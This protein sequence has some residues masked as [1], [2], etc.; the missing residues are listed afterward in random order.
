MQ[1]S[2][3]HLGTAPPASVRYPILV[4]HITS[5]WPQRLL[6]LG[7]LCCSNPLLRE[8]GRK[9]CYGPQLNQKLHHLGPVVRSTGGCGGSE[10]LP[11]SS[12]E[13]RVEGCKDK[14]HPSEASPV[15][16]FFSAPPLE[17][18]IQPWIHH[19]LI[20]WWNQ[21]FNQIMLKSSTNCW[22]SHQHVGCFLSKDKGPRHSRHSSYTTMLPFDQ[23][24][25]HFWL[26]SLRPLWPWP[27]LP[28]L[29]L[30]LHLEMAVLTGGRWREC[31][32]L[33][34]LPSWGGG[35]LDWASL[36]TESHPESNLWAW[37]N[38][39]STQRYSIFDFSN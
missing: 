18:S 17:G 5:A 29:G 23:C 25:A 3:L 31:T 36:L 20:H 27:G 21:P 14:L 13:A 16:Y 34:P 33:P 6:L 11:P 9:V 37:A 2:V 32:Q 38:D 35:D 12:Q 15:S 30:F 22:P 1:T 7:C 19:Q 28:H 24:Q 10:L 39:K 26:C 4:P 8:T